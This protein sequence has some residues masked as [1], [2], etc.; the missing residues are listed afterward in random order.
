MR[1]HQE[2]RVATLGERFDIPGPGVAQNV[3]CAPF[4]PVGD[5][6]HEPPCAF[7][8]TPVPIDHDDVIGLGTPAGAYDRVDF[9]GVEPPAFFIQRGP[10]AGMLP[11][12][13]P[14]HP[15]DVSPHHHA[16]GYSLLPALAWCHSSR[17]RPRFLKSFFN[18]R[19]QSL[20]YKAMVGGYRGGIVTGPC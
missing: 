2:D 17:R 4:Q 12:G 5:E 19:I 3:A 11:R 16:H 20:L 1:A 18:M 15:L 7:V 6:A 8:S 13:D 14:G 9:L 10:A